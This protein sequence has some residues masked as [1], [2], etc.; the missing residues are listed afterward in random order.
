M[1]TLSEN[2]VYNESPHARFPMTLTRAS[3]ELGITVQRLSR[4]L[5]TL[6]VP[7]SRLGYSVLLDSTGYARVKRALA[8][9][10]IKRGRKKKAS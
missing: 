9:G 3:R 7:V 8:R 1:S 5:K 4:Y 2:S 6:E 10:E